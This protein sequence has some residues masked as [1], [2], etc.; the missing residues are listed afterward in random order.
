MICAKIAKL[1]PKILK[2][3][4]K[5]NI[6]SCPETLVCAIC[7]GA[8]TLTYFSPETVLICLSIGYD[9]G[10]IAPVPPGLS[11]YRALN[12]LAQGVSL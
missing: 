7:D 12:D 11:T 6:A 1:P 3:S 9:V 2:F 10:T 5:F 8:N 4:G